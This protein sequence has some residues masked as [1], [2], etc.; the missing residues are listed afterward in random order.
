MI[1]ND[2]IES[3][4]EF[5]KELMEDALKDVEGGNVPSERLHLV[6]RELGG[7]ASALGRYSL[8]LD[9]GEQAE[10]WF[11]ESATYYLKGITRHREQ[12]KNAT[13]SQEAYWEN[14]PQT[15]RD[16]LYSALLSRRESVLEKV[17]KLTLET[18][19]SFVEQYPEPIPLSVYYYVKTLAAFVVN[20]ESRQNYLNRLEEVS[21]E[22]DSDLMVLFEARLTTLRGL[23]DDAPKEVYDGLQN[24]VEYHCRE[25]NG[26]PKTASDVVDLQSCALLRLAIL[27]GMEPS[28]ESRYIPECIS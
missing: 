28:L 21:E 22:L 18:D 26:E 14:E 17:G 8:A 10:D 27:K 19:E 6:Y 23:Q 11:A 5:T 13:S 4:F 20:D 3:Q 12:R 7:D 15:L 16:A 25:I 9:N 24:L 1:T 2:K